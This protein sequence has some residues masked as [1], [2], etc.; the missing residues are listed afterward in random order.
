MCLEK[1]T[2]LLACLFLQSEIKGA[3][4]SVIT[5]FLSGSVPSKLIA[6][7]KKALYKSKDKFIQVVYLMHLNIAYV[8]SAF[9]GLSVQYSTYIYH[10]AIRR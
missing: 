8:S 7:E 4:E 1:R 10:R 9:S 2:W 6:N 5:C 3:I